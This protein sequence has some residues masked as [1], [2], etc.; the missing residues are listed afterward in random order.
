MD[1]SLNFLSTVKCPSI[2]PS[3]L[4]CFSTELA[5]LT[6][7]CVISRITSQDGSHLIDSLGIVMCSSSVPSPPPL[8]AVTSYITK[9]FTLLLLLLLLLWQLQIWRFSVVMKLT[10]IM[11]TIILTWT[12]F[13]I[14]AFVVFTMITIY[15]ITIVIVMMLMM[16][17]LHIHEVSRYSGGLAVSGLRRLN[18]TRNDNADNNV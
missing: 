10:A 4:G 16:S 13:F 12:L 11:I 17:R 15:H 6:W 1:R 8:K 18:N 5:K 7:N 9:N 3:F 2:V 14:I